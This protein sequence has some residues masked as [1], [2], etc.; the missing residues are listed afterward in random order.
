M[1]STRA[2]LAAFAIVA[3]APAAHAA[4]ITLNDLTTPIAVNAIV[5]KTPAP[6]TS[7]VVG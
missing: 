7:D 4:S 1:T 2:L 5:E 3:M 6:I